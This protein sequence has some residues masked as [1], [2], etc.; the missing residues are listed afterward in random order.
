MVVS[1]WFLREAIPDVVC[2]GVNETCVD[3][4]LLFTSFLAKPDFPCDV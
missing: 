2:D 1:C 4:D 3:S